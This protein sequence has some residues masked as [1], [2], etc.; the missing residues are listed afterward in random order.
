MILTE[1]LFVS[2]CIMLAHK[3]LFTPMPGATLNKLNTIDLT[4]S[5]VMI[6]DVISGVYLDTNIPESVMI[7]DDKSASIFVYDG[8]DEFSE[9]NKTNYATDLKIYQYPHR[10]KCI[11]IAP[12]IIYKYDR[13]LA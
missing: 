3:M 11:M 2:A 10:E 6:S 9:I 13:D 1:A 5:S 4:D 8:V 12:G 7:T